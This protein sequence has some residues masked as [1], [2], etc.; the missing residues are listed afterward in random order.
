MCMQQKFKMLNKDVEV[1]SAS[2]LKLKEFRVC[3]VYK[4][5]N[6]SYECK[7]QDLWLKTGEWDG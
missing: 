4:A 7:I 2:R 5:V 6:F 3:S 1:H